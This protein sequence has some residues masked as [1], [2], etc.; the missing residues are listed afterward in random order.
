MVRAESLL[1]RGQQE[2]EVSPI[3]DP[4]A[5]SHRSSSNRGTLHKFEV[6]AIEANGDQT[7]SEGS[8][9]TSPPG[10]RVECA[11]RLLAVNDTDTN[12]KASGNWRTPV[13]HLQP[14]KAAKMLG[15]VCRESGTEPDGNRTDGNVEIVDHLGAGHEPC[16][17][18]AKLQGR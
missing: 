5:D 12:Q 16:F 18:A 6:L 8:F 4:Y 13:L 9:V 10:G 2:V 14:L 17:L 3:Y 7:I 1:P 11:R 15:V